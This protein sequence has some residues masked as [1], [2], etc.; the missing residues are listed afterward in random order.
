MTTLRLEHVGVVV[1]DLPAAIE[2]FAAVGLEIEGQ[3][4]VEGDLV[5]RVI[6]LKG[7]RSDLAIMQTPDG[8]GKIELAKF[9]APTFD[10][11]SGPEPS[12]APGLRHV[13]FAVED[14]HAV[15]AA[16]SALGYELVGTIENYEDIYLLCYI[17]G[18]AGTVVELAQKIG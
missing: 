15:V 18:P 4:S 16:V 7:A 1:D 10:G 5:D 9:H 3:G 8:Q 13:L 17:R 2:F 12:N 14:I 6:G 11:V